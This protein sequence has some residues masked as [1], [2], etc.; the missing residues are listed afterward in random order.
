MISLFHSHYR[1][2]KALYQ[3][4]ERVLIP[5]MLVFGFIVDYITFKTIQVH[6]S[7]TVLACYFAL[8]GIFIAFTRFYDAGKI[9]EKLRF[10]RLFAPLGI[11]Y[12]FGALLGASFV[13]YWFSASFNAS[14]PFI[15]ILAGLM[16]G[17]ET[18]RTQIQR[19]SVQL[20]VYYFISFSFF[21]LTL[22]YL[23]NDLGPKLF[24][25]AGFASLG[26]MY[27]YVR[28]VSVARD[29]FRAS[30]GFVLKAVF[31]IFITM[32]AFYFANIIPPIPLALR[33]AGAYHQVSR[34]TGGYALVREQENL[35]QR[36]MPGRTVHLAPGERLYVYTAIF[37]PGDLRTRIYHQ[38]H[39]YDEAA[40][41]WVKR[42][43]LSFAISGGR[44]EGYRGY[45]VK[46]AVQPGR[47]RVSV[48]TDRGQ[49]L[50]RIA[51]TVERADA[52]PELEIIQ[53]H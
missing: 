9:S 38:W 22:P 44:K 29:D 36:M 18:L 13:F 27:A 6:I 41:A 10:V 1:R 53:A 34:G 46:S 20:S 37:A 25:L 21:S 4:Y 50:G 8:A 15:M 47:W 23:A 16:V 7:L 12:T 42:D 49:S 45:S 35:F 2:A 48:E 26:Y 33:E 30:R 52:A 19:H 11:Q 3:R 24:L 43:R 31:A 32:N 39:F 17:N 40:N 5:G 14:W 28:L 51:F